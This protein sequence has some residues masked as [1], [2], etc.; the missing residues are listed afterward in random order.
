M[1]RK[2][3]AIS[4][5]Y[6][7]NSWK[8]VRNGLFIAKSSGKHLSS[9]Y[10]S[11]QVCDY[12]LQDQAVCAGKERCMWLACVRIQMNHT[13]CACGGNPF[14]F[15]STPYS[16]DIHHFIRIAIEQKFNGTKSKQKKKYNLINHKVELDG[17]QNCLIKSLY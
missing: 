3:Y 7:S 4:R 17:V 9:V 8:W 13:R 15:R 6:C 2:H 5:I 16:L 1:P 11:P 14:S 12:N 10:L